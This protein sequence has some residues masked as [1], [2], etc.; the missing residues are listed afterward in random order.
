MQWTLGTRAVL[1]G[2]QRGLATPTE[3]NVHRDA[4]CF[5][6]KTRARH[7]TTE[8]LLNNGWRLVVGGGWWSLGAVP[9]QKKLGVLKDSSAGHPRQRVQLSPPGGPQSVDSIN[10]LGGRGRDTPRTCN[11]RANRQ[12]IE[13]ASQSVARR[14]LFGRARHALPHPLLQAAFCVAA[15]LGLGIVPAAAPHCVATPTARGQGEGAGGGGG[16]RSVRRAHLKAQLTTGLH[17]QGTG[18]HQ[19]VL[20]N[21]LQHALQNGRQ[22]RQRFARARLGGQ[23]GVPAPPEDAVRPDLD[24][25]GG[26]V[27][28][29]CEDGGHLRGSGACQGDASLSR[30]FP[31]D[32]VTPHAGDTRTKGQPTP[33]RP[34]L[35]A[36]KKPSLPLQ[37]LNNHVEFHSVPQTPSKNNGTTGSSC[38]HRTVSGRRGRGG[39]GGCWNKRE[40]AHRVRTVPR[41]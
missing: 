7:K 9:N 26:H 11:A 18:P 31:P 17:D 30:T 24:G 5:M 15:A 32:V 14:A 19:S 40:Y 39:G 34:I 33:Q 1:K 28:R 38:V 6:A 20:L 16:L 4:L 36:K 23:H 2:G 10:M 12:D 37:P 35:P 29:P 27:P 25:H 8:A 41:I 3:T 21:G 22:V 13:V